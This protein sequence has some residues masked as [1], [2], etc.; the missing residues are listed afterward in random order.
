VTAAGL[1]H[2]GPKSAFLLGR[3]MVSS[4]E[5]HIK[6]S[7]TAFLRAIAHESP[8]FKFP[9]GMP[10]RGDAVRVNVTW[11]TCK[12]RGQDNHRPLLKLVL[13]VYLLVDRLRNDA[14]I[15]VVD[16]CPEET[17]DWKYY[18]LSL[19]WHHTHYLI[20]AQSGVAPTR[21]DYHAIAATAAMPE[22]AEWRHDE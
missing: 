9:R 22:E 20:R 6:D 8:E 15:R 4:H 13:R 11:D 5:L 16:F 21:P 19:H 12:Q 2:K 18:P 17:P 10:E 7:R 1:T 3:W 14:E